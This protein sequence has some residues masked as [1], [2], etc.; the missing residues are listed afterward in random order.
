MYNLRCWRSHWWQLVL[1]ERKNCFIKTEI[2]TL[3]LKWALRIKIWPS[4]NTSFYVCS[5]LRRTFVFKPR[6]MCRPAHSDLSS[7]PTITCYFRKLLA[8]R[9]L[10]VIRLVNI[11]AM[12][13][14]TRPFITHSEPWTFSHCSFVHTAEVTSL[15]L[16]SF[17]AVTYQGRQILQ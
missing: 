4:R 7:A 16:K 13:V 11:N 9:F 15:G 8:L 17:V 14:Y 12:F 1:T 3:A 6:E 5:M 2:T 10:S